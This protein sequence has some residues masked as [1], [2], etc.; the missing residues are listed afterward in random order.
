MRI[1]DC[2]VASNETDML[3][4]RRRELREVVDEFVVVEATRTHTG[5]P[6]PLFFSGIPG[7]HHH[8]VD[9]LP[10]VFAPTLAD[11]WI[12]ENFQRNCIV[13]P[14]GLLNA[15]DD[16]IILIS[17]I[18]EIPR[19]QSVAELPSLLERYK[20]VVF[21]QLMKRF[22]LNNDSKF[23]DNNVGWLGTVACKFLWLKSVTPQSARIG[24]PF[25]QR[26]ARVSANYPRALYPYEY[27]LRNA[28]WHLTW[29]GG[30]HA[31]HSKMRSH[32]ETR[33][34]HA[35]METTSE[36]RFG[37]H[38]HRA[39]REQHADE[40]KE[41]LSSLAPRGV[42]IANLASGAIGLLDIP[43]CIKADPAAFEHLFYL[44]EP[45]D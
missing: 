15:Q 11:R 38:N 34:A 1:I 4:I 30:L 27:W 6:K 33:S 3:E 42:E 44:A 41:F 45:I 22:F 28:G 37:R 35:M 8:I 17:D 16:D 36:G 9:D 32:P 23:S 10:V 21:E 26:A 39:F 29:T 43:N 25:S 19:A 12:V 14:L 31:F 18:D 20:I 2:V 5:H 7:I 13:R 40:L 24:D